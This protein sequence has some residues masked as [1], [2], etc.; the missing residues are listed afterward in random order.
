MASLLQGFEEVRLVKP[1]GKIVMT[2]TDNAVKF[3]KATAIVLG[4]PAYVKVLVNE[5]TKQIAVTPTTAKA[6]NGIKFSKGEGKQAASIS[7]KDAAVLEAVKQFFDIAEAPEGQVAYQSV[8]GESHPN[9]K[10][11]I[12]DAAK[13]TAGVMKR[14]GRKK[15]A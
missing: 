5:K 10:V 7:V 12:F 8:P 11:V 2:V 14:R 15:A 9:D 6:D 4:H 1:V 3:N 13:A